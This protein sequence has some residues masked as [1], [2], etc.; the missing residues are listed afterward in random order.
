MYMYEIRSYAAIS[1][2]A[3]RFSVIK[4]IGDQDFSKIINIFIP[5]LI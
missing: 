1:S 4:E 3:Q 5:T 2:I